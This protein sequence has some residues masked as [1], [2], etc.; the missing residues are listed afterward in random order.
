MDGWTYS[1]LSGI[2]ESISVGG[3]GYPGFNLDG[4]KDPDDQVAF[5][6]FY[7]S[8]D[9]PPSISQTIAFEAGDYTFVFDTAKRSTN[10][11]LEIHVLLDGVDIYNTGT[12]GNNAFEQESFQF[13]VA[14][15]G[16]HTLTLAA[17]DVTG[18][19]SGDSTVFIDNAGLFIV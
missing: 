16:D 2:A 4:F 5:L 10:D 12:I 6:Q 19:L 3:P 15:A 13:N 1:G 7:G 9:V 8:N 18:A 11:D 17:Y 14:A